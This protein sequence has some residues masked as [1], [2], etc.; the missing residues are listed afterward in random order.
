MAYRICW[1]QGSVDQILQTE[2][3]AGNDAVFLAAHSP[4]EGFEVSGSRAA[5]V[6]EATEQC[7]LEALVRDT[8]RHAFCIVRGEPGSGKSHLIRWLSIQWK[9]RQEND[10]VILVQ[11]ADGSLQN[12]LEQLRKVLP[13]ED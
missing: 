11:R 8:T 10:V 2:A 3:L 5:E 13:V 4:I 9:R 6:T 12:T 1:E 7:L